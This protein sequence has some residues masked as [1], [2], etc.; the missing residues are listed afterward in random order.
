MFSINASRC[1]GNLDKEKEAE[2]ISSEHF[3][4]SSTREGKVGSVS[5]ICS[6]QKGLGGFCSKGS[7]LSKIR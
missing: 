6:N 5:H 3:Q 2:G 1:R 4:L 7:V